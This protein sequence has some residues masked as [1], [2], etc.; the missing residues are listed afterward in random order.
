MISPEIQALIKQRVAEAMA[1]DSELDGFAMELLDQYG[2]Q[3]APEDL[4]PDED[5]AM[6]ETMYLVSGQ[7]IFNLMCV[8]GYKRSPAR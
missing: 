3:V 8:L 2:F 7:T 4:Q 1:T 5:P 6:L